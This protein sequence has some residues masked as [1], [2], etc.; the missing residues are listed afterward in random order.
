MM[1]FHTKRFFAVFFFLL[2]LLAPAP[3]FPGEA[4]VPGAAGAASKTFQQMDKNKDGKLSMQEMD[5]EAARIFNEHDKNGDGV[6]ER[7][8]YER[9]PGEKTKFEELDADRNGKLSIEELRRAAKERFD[10]KDRNADGA[11]SEEELR[12]SPR[13]HPQASPLLGVY[14]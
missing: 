7:G 11:L 8:E 6:L 12:A 9:I 2:S 1:H 13:Y 10:R 5:R 4:A 14:F 3:A